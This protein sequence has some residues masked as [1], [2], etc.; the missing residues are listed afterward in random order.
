MEK[1]IFL[2]TDD[3]GSLVHICESEQFARNFIALYG[4]AN[5]TIDS[6]EVC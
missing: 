1:L 3:K 5:Y 6:E 2:V 4:N